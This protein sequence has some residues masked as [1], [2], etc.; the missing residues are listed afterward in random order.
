M[1]RMAKK[2]LGESLEDKDLRNPRLEDVAEEELNQ[3]GEEVGET[4]VSG[5]SS[6]TNSEEGDLTPATTEEV[7]AGLKPLA[8]APASPKGKGKVKPSSHSTSSPTER[9]IKPKKKVTKKATTATDKAPAHATEKSYRFGATR[10]IVPGNFPIGCFPAYL[11]PYPTNDTDAYDELH[12]LKYFNDFSIYHNDYLQQAIEELK[13]EHPNVIIAYGNYYD[14]FLWLFSRDNMLGFDPKSLQKGCCG[15]GGATV[16]SN[17]DERHISVDIQQMIPVLMMN[18]IVSGFDPKS[19][20]KGCCGSG[21]ATICSN[22]DEQCKSIT[23]QSQYSGF[24]DAMSRGV[25]H[26]KG[27]CKKEEKVATRSEK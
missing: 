12:C 24:S 22:P 19:L 16:C 23:P 15:S 1:S 20:Q 14:S 10:I 3:E 17:L 18:F 2:I 9:V 21:G 4:N 7:I 6:E 8:T 26:I 13:Q 27:K 11:S 5:A 25:T